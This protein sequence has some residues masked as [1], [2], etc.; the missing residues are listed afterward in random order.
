MADS[1]TYLALANSMAQTAASY[2]QAANLNK[3]NRQFV[4]EQN[5]LNRDLYREGIANTWEM[6]RATNEYNSPANQRKLLEEAGYNPASLSGMNGAANSNQ[7]SF[8]SPPTWQHHNIK[9]L[10]CRVL[11]QLSKI[12]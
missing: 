12:C 6:W 8:Q 5:E 2:G 4:T 3:K 10:T 1:D 7:G 9:E 11:A